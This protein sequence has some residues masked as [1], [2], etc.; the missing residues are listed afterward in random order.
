[1]DIA[2]HCRTENFRTKSIGY[3][4]S[5]DIVDFFRHSV[6]G[7]PTEDVEVYCARVR[8]ENC[9]GNCLLACETLLQTDNRLSNVYLDLVYI[10][11][12]QLGWE[13]SPLQVK[14]D[15]VKAVSSALLHRYR[16]VVLQSTTLPARS[17]DTSK[18]WSTPSI[19]SH[20]RG[21]AGRTTSEWR[22]LVLNMLLARWACTGTCHEK[23]S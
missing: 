15:H 19:S 23:K 11:K 22:Y 17:R 7:V 20:A 14:K 10:R 2:S 21:W 16:Q 9:D 3:W 8:E 1:M 13:K 12:W 5:H 6:S 4:S 18:E